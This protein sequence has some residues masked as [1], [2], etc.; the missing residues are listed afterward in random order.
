MSRA[1]LLLF[2]N[3]ERD[4]LE[5]V[6]RGDLLFVRYDAGAHQC[7]W[8]Q[9]EITR[10]EF[11]ELQSGRHGEYRVLMALQGR[12]RLRGEDPCRQNWIPPRQ[13]SAPP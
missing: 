7:A 11:A 5:I 10:G 12:I 1:D 9:D 4:G 2:G 13:V 6:E 8:R 3:L